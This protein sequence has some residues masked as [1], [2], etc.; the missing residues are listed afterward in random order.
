LATGIGVDN[1]DIVVNEL[2]IA[3][4]YDPSKGLF[5]G[6]RSFNL[7]RLGT[8]GALQEEIAPGSTVMAEYGI[9]IDGLFHYYRDTR[10]VLDTK[11]ASAFIRD[12]AWPAELPTPYIA[13]CSFA[14]ANRLAIADHNGFTIT[15]PGFYAP[16]GRL[17]AIP[18]AWPDLNSQIAAFRFNNRKVLNYEMETSALYALGRTLGHKTLTICLVVANR[19]RKE[20][21]RDYQ[22][23]MTALA[24]KVLN[25]LTRG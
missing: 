15:A 6:N 1:I 19:K 14:L 12:T 16:Q 20:F 11:A 25:N 9:G 7:V 22:P 8:S 23:A 13:G 10:S 24:E 18:L 4:N 2:H 21:L 17:A 3:A 5:T